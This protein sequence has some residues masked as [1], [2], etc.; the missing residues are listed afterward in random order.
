MTEYFHFDLKD[1]V[2]AAVLTVDDKQVF[3]CFFFNNITRVL[4]VV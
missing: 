2:S 1:A 4:L 3:F